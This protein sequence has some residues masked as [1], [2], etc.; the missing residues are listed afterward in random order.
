VTTTTLIPT[1]ISASTLIGDDVCDPTGESIGKIKEIMLDTSHGRIMYAVVS[2]GGF[3]GMGDRLFA[4]PWDAMRLDTEEKR[5]I[6]NV[7]AER[8]KEAPGFDKD[9]WPD[10]ADAAFHHGTYSY[11]RV[12][13][14]WS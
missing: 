6:L 9:N 13:P 7:D 1:V 5:F 3:L 12:T 10:F 11:Y 4:V 14:Y 2:V 8:L